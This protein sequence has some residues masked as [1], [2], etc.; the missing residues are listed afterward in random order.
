MKSKVVAVFFLILWAVCIS[1]QE[2]YSKTGIASFYADKF[3]GRPTANGEIYYHAKR[4]AAHRTLAFG[5][6]VKVTNLENNKYV[7]VRINDR[8][9]FVDNR[10]IDLS[11]SAA[12]ELDFVQNGLAKVSVQLIASM[13]DLPDEQNDHKDKESK[14]DYFKVNTEKVFPKG[15]GIQVGS[16]KNNENIFKLIEDLKQKY[17]EEIFVEIANVKGEKVYRIIIGS[18]NSDAYLHNLKN[19][20]SKDFPSCFIVTFKY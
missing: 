10:I 19:K 20:L 14:A 7:V 12:E 13:D 1:A 4:T 2:K 17:K 6:I 9:P 5:S 16:Y 11:K 15:K 3:E 8:G 18:S